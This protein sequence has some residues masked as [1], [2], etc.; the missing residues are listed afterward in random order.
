MEEARTYTVFAGTKWVAAG[1]LRSILGVTKLRLDA[2]ASEA[3]L[4]FED[5]TGQQVD[6]DFRGTLDEVLERH[7]PAAP[8]RSGPGRPKLGVI[9]REGTLLPRH[10]EWLESQPHGISA[11]LRRLVEEAKKRDPGKDRARAAR[12][13]T[14]RFMWAMAGNLPGFE[15]ASR[16]LFAGDLPRFGALIGGWP[17]DIRKHL[18]R[19]AG[20]S[21]GSGEETAAEAH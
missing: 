1:D 7:A 10:W 8:V 20:A 12:D 21:V 17:E 19:M 13:A 9:S 15:E 5:Q 11:T 6:F 3:V 2:G 14:S 4:I 16:A 18:M